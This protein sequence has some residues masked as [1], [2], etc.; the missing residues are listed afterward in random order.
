MKTIITT[1]KTK[2]VQIAKDILRQENGV[3]RI[4]YSIVKNTSCNCGCGETPAINLIAKI[5]GDYRDI[6]I[7]ICK[8]CAD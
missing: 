6:T 7:G 1:S 3:S 5:K 4:G 2:A 8:Q